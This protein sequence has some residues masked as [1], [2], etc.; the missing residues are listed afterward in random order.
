MS[1]SR[2]ENMKTL[3]EI[4]ECEKEF[5]TPEDVKT[6]LRCDSQSISMQARMDPSKLGFRVI[7]MGTRVRIPKQ[8]F[9]KW[10]KGVGIGA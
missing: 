6:V 9:V 1:R 5:L 2:S 10:C 8:A 7:V 3:Q 4:E